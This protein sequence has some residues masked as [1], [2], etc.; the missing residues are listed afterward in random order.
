MESSKL[1]KGNVYF[2]LAY[3]DETYTWPLI[4]SY[5]YLG[6]DVFEKSKESREIHFCFRILGTEDCLEVTE[7]QLWMILDIPGLY[8]ALEEWCRK[9]PAQNRS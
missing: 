7:S 2:R 4:K 9:Y 8:G 3:E 1:R 5:E 6:E